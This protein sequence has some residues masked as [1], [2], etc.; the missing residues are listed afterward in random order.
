[1]PVSLTDGS[2]VG[3][4]SQ[5]GMFPVLA[6]Q[7]LDKPA[8]LLRT[9][10]NPRMDLV[11]LILKDSASQSTPA[12]TAPPGMSAAQFALVQRMLAAR[13][14]GAQASAAQGAPEPRRGPQIHLVLWRMGDE[15]SAV[16][17]VPLSF[18][19]VMDKT[20][21]S[22]GAS[23]QEH[24]DVHLHDLVWSPR[25]DRVAV[26][27]SV[28]RTSVAS[29]STAT[30]RAT[31]FLRTYSVQDGRLLSTVTIH[32]DHTIS[33]N[34]SADG[35]AQPMSATWHEVDFGINDDAVDGSSESILTKFSPLPALPA[36]DTFASAGGTGNLMPH[37]LRMMQMSGQK[38]PPSF[39]FPSHLALQGRGALASIPR[40]AKADT[41]LHLLEGGDAVLTLDQDRALPL[42]PETVVLVSRAAT[43]RVH[44]ILDGQIHIGS[45]QIPRSHEAR[46][47]EPSSCASLML[48]LSPDMT[49]IVSVS[50]NS[51]LAISQQTLELPLP[52]TTRYGAL[53]ARRRIA[54]VARASHLLGFY[55]G[56]AL[57]SASALQQVYQ[58]EFVQKVIN[59]WSKNIDDLDMKFG[60]DMKY[61]LINVLLTGRAGPAAEQFL[62]GNL[63]EG[64]LT[65]LEQQTHTAMYALKKLISESLKPALE[66]SIVCL[67]GLFGQCRF[68]GGSDEGLRQA[69]KILQASLNSTLSLA[70]E[71]DMEALVSQEFYR[72]CR[73]ERERQERIKQD[74]DE[75]RLPITY[76]VQFVATY[77]DRGFENGEIHARMGNNVAAEAIEEIL[78]EVPRKTSL[79]EALQ[80][81]QT[82]LA[83]PGAASAKAKPQQEKA[84]LSEKSNK[85]PLAVLP[86]LN[87]AVEM[88]GSQLT[89]L[90][91][92]GL[93]RSV[94]EPTA[95]ATVAKH[96][97]WLARETA[98]ALS[99]SASSENIEKRAARICT[100]SIISAETVLSAYILH[101]RD[102]PSSSSCVLVV[103]QNTLAATDTPAIVL[104]TV[105]GEQDVIILDIGFYGDAE[106]LVLAQ[107][108]STS[109][110]VLLGFNVAD[111]PF[112][113]DFEDEGRDAIATVTPSRATEFERD[114][115]P[116][117]LAVNT[118]KQT[119][120]VVEE[121]GR[122]V[123]YLDISLVE[124]ADVAMQEEE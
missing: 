80:A 87:R 40:L 118:N 98:P 24:E 102:A 3:D 50:S 29:T 103:R 60:A 47:D 63:T 53:S 119:V 78:A 22:P 1:M 90:L 51:D 43:A 108:T 16:W 38:Q 82:F 93:D 57:D 54:A 66:R 97:W 12:P 33:S 39:R 52:V 56:Y 19:Q 27:A 67:S 71:V 31:T 117:K 4:G 96:S 85:V 114:F 48:W 124:L 55:L 59:E 101:S 34:N 6:D 86:M 61:E 7:R 23:Q 112:T 15:S 115:K 62:L 88:L 65:R 37:Q 11:L 104:F 13:Q 69:L 45:L 92:A 79:R 30:W 21:N 116:I 73:T 70:K 44:L 68:S 121:D 35:F 111:L 26:L 83:A 120:T 91:D 123:M 106:L 49:R 41:D 25:G 72:W 77:I 76:D 74:Q 84:E 20:S 8:T 109:T 14:R 64:V 122:R 46:P 5:I 89:G 110:S 99:I 28:K 58:N 9:S 17:S 95:P 42:S 100:T 75:P 18:D 36:A 107:L 94:V 32:G 105:P 113:L 81:A 2:I 10:A